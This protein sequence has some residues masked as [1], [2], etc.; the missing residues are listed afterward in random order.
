M[1][2]QPGTWSTASLMAGHGRSIVGF[3]RPLLA[4]ALCLAAAGCSVT[5]ATPTTFPSPAAATPSRSPSDPTPAQATDTQ[6][7]YRLVFELPQTDWHTTDSITGT[8][9]LSFVG[10]GGV[11]F[12]SSGGGPFTF[13]FAELSG[14]RQ[15]EGEMT[16]DCTPYRLDAGKPM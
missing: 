3:S 16:A 13:D 4:M 11:D 6:G 12:G 14:A 5:A 10:A 2:T 15:V 9:T 8:A 7:S 1:A